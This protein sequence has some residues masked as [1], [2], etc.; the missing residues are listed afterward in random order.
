M[1][2]IFLDARTSQNASHANSINVPTTPS[3]VAF[4]Q[5]G[6]NV[7]G[8]NPSIPLRVQFQGIA[9]FKL[10]PTAFNN[11]NLIEIIIVR[12]TNPNANQI[13]SGI[14]TMVLNG[15]ENGPQEYSFA[16]SDYNPPI[17]SGL[18]VY[19]GFIRNITGNHESDVN[20]VGPE[21]FDATAFG[22]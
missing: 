20:R 3:Y 2:P 22:N 18:L 5:V 21:S 1:A 7:T 9:T 16:A 13:F 14:K 12:G 17:G 10:S 19:T 4:A 6:L 15:S 8:A 11:T